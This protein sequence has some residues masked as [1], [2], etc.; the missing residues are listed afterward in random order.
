M[1]VIKFPVSRTWARPVQFV[2]NP[3]ILAWRVRK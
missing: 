3:V 2:A 1:K